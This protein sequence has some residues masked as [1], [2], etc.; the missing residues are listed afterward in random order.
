[1]AEEMA[2]IIQVRSRESF[3]HRFHGD[4]GPREIEMF[5]EEI[6][7]AWADDLS[8]TKFQKVEVIRRY[9]GSAVKDELACYPAEL[10]ADPE[11]LLA[12][13]RR[14]YGECKSMSR[15]T[16]IVVVPTSLCVSVGEEKKVSQEKRDEKFSLTL[17]EDS[18]CVR[19]VLVSP[20][21]PQKITSRVTLVLSIRLVP[22]TLA[23]CTVPAA[24]AD[25]RASP[26]RCGIVDIF[27]RFS[28][29]D[30]LGVVKVFVEKWNPRQKPARSSRIWIFWHDL[31]P[32]VS[33]PTADNS[34]QRSLFDFHFA[35]Q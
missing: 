20:L 9:L 19:G 23:R 13:L 2:Q 8:I 14:A 6:R 10:I 25:S 22:A 24:V 11:K 32:S 3:V 28:S 18:Y 5:E 35:D 30:L 12:T 1:M 16:G 15:Q 7:H 21:S 34:L 31:E 26:S 29:S 33:E 27:L 17:R 4:G